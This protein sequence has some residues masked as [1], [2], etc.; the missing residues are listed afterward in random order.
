M[1]VSIIL[2]LVVF[3]LTNYIAD[4]FKSSRTLTHVP[5]SYYSCNRLSMT[6]D[7]DNHMEDNF[8]RLQWL[9]KARDFVSRKAAGVLTAGAVS[10]SL[11][12]APSS[13]FARGKSISALNN[14]QILG[15]RESPGATEP[16]VDYISR[17]GAVLEVEVEEVDS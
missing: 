8:R 11:L 17:R 2:A 6:S 13:A 9:R 14:G 10:S 3:F 7:T 1:M 5:R 15:A 16:S 12:L 4:S